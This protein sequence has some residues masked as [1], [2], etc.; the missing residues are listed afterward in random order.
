MES[1]VGHAQK[2]PLKGLRFESLEEAQAS[3]DHWELHWADTRI[4]GTT[5][6]QVSAMFVEERPALLPLPVEP[7]R[8]Y[9]F[10]ERT[11]HLDGCVEVES[12]YYGA[13]PGWIGRQVKVQWNPV[14]V[15]LLDPKTGQLLREHFRQKRGT[16][17]IQ[18]RD[19]S[20]RT[21]LRMQ[22]LLWRAEK[23]GANIGQLCRV[24]YDRRGEPAIRRIL[25][26]LSLAK[27][28]GLAAV[29]QACATALEMGVPDYRFVRRYL[30]RSPQLP[31]TLRQIDPLIRELVQYRELIEQRTQEME[32]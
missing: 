24:L 18:E 7:F 15:R 8:Y 19:R 26:V 20:P 1:G 14:Y 28:Q 2:T 23:A 9:Q 6:R 5:K 3:L 11:V 12:A 22:Q 30:E 21:P 32:S 4:H 16:H 17:V 31:L 27:K 25:G 13:P 10:G 29:E